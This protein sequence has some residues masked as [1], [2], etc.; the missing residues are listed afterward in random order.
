MA[1]N[2][3]SGA[4]D[5]MVLDEGGE[6]DRGEIEKRRVRANHSKK[7]GCCWPHCKR[8]VDISDPIEGYMPKVPSKDATGGKTRTKRKKIFDLMHREDDH[9]VGKSLH[10]CLDH[11][12]TDRKDPVGSELFNPKDGTL[13]PGIFPVDLNT[14]DRIKAKDGLFKELRKKMYDTRKE[15]FDKIK[16]A[17]NNTSP[18]SA[19]ATTT[20][21]DEVMLLAA[22]LKKVKSSLKKT[23]K[24]LEESEKNKRN[25]YRFQN[26]DQDTVINLCSYSKQEI[27]DLASHIEEDLALVK[28]MRDV[29]N[30]KS[31]EPLDITK[32]RALKKEILEAKARNKSYL[33]GR[34]WILSIEDRVFMTLTYLKQGMNVKCCALLFGGVKAATMHRVLNETMFELRAAL[35]DIFPCHATAPVSTETGVDVCGDEDDDESETMAAT[36][37]FNKKIEEELEEEE[38]A[39]LI[40]LQLHRQFSSKQYNIVWLID[41]FELRINVPGSSDQQKAFYSSYKHYHTLKFLV[42]IDYRSGKIRYISDGYPGSISDNEICDVSG[43]AK[44]VGQNWKEELSKTGKVAGVLAD[45]GYT[46]FKLFKDNKAELFTPSVLHEGRFS[47]AEALFTHS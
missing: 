10:Y 1:Q 42:G 45:K 35:N 33:S 34:D 17:D 19:P 11:L 9:T 16:L 27:T 22:E 39:E 32:I 20:V 38:L 29:A 46:C 23:A 44:M 14:Y 6:I 31:G 12:L 25:N 40:G 26:C 7:R 2:N 24:K 18:P 43:F 47:A 15:I 8:F 28:A 13:A 41:C 30:V 37:N 3:T 5:N 4:V 36:Q 21:A